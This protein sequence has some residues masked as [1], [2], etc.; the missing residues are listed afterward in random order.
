MTVVGFL[1]PFVFIRV[2]AEG[3]MGPGSDGDCA[4]VNWGFE[5]RIGDEGWISLLGCFLSMATRMRA[6]KD[7]S[8]ITWDS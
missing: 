8:V 5:G 4:T 7:G 1:G 3:L 6:M 2:E